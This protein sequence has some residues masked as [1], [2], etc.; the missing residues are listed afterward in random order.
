METGVSQL[1]IAIDTKMKTDDVRAL[2]QLLTVFRANVEQLFIDSPVI[3]LLVSQVSLCTQR[4]YSP[5]LDQSR[6]GKPV[7]GDVEERK[8][9]PCRRFP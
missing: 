1:G 2:I 8:N 5:T 9:T 3:E 7:D 4:S 6:A